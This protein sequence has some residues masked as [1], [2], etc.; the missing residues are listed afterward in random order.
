MLK[1]KLQQEKLFLILTVISLLALAFFVIFKVNNFQQFSPSNSE[2]LSSTLTDNNQSPDEDWAIQSIKKLPE[3]KR[4]QQDFPNSTFQAQSTQSGSWQVT[5][6]DPQT[7]ETHASYEIDQDTQEI[8]AIQG[9]DIQKLEDLKERYRLQYDLNR[10]LYSLTIPS[11]YFT[12][13]SPSPEAITIDVAFFDDQSSS[14]PAFWLQEQPGQTEIISLLE[15]LTSLAS[16]TLKETKS[17]RIGQYDWTKSTYQACQPPTCLQQD[18]LHYAYGILLDNQSLILYNYTVPE[19]DFEKKI[20]AT[21][22][23]ALSD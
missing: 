18:S 8:L 7:N 2:D 19:Q 1:T 17:V 12:K 20:L 21:F 4:Y 23:K 15:Q 5:I 14:Q 6:K 3:I 10:P 9:L 13:N 16:T 11:A 22:Q